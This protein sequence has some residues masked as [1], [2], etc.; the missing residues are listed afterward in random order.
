V[1]DIDLLLP[2]VFEKAA[3]CP[4]PTAIRH[5]R[6]AAIEFCRRTRV[7]R[8]SDKFV[9]SGEAC[10]GLAPYEGSQIYEIT[11]AFYFPVDA[12]A[13]PE[14]DG[15]PLE[16]VTVDWLDTEHPNWRKELG[17]PKYITQSTPNTVRITPFSEGSLRLEMVLLPSIDTLEFPDI[18]VDTYSREVADGALASVLLLPAEWGNPQL[19][20]MHGSAFNGHLDR[21]A[22]S[23]PKGQQRARRR[24]SRPQFF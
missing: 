3:N 10:E 5:L 7:W 19:G 2:R 20:A 18:L 4:E 13:D 21:F 16:A 17:T 23:L 11:A 24:G 15:Q 6:D 12:D 1:K 9:L 8:E 14:Y 22:A